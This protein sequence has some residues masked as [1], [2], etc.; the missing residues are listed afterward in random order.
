MMIQDGLVQLAD[1]WE[2][3]SLWNLSLEFWNALGRAQPRF[4]PRPSLSLLFK[5]RTAAACAGKS[6]VVLWPRLLLLDG[7]KK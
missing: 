6:R 2:G 5:A 7:L 1:L 4:R 3:T